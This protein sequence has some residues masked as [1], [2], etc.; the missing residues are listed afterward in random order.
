M[1]FL[2]RP[3]KGDSHPSL[4]GYYSRSTDSDNTAKTTL[5]T[6]EQR[7]ESKEPLDL[8]TSRTGRGIGCWFR[9]RAHQSGKVDT[10]AAKGK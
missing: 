3:Q 10:I 7:K 9:F 6:G 4:L 8:P 5:E 2:F 1:L